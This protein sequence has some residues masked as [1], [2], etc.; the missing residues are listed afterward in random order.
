MSA[1]A[2]L[3]VA[4]EACAGRGGGATLDES[5]GGVST[6]VPVACWVDVATAIRDDPRSA[7]GFF[8]WLSAYDDSDHGL[9]VVA[10]V[11]SIG[12]RHAVVLR[13]HVAREG[14][15]LA[16][17]TGVWAGADWHE[18]ETY[19]MFAIDFTGHPRLVPLLLPN[20]FEG[21]PLRKDFVLATRVAMAWPGAKEPG[22]SDRDLVADQPGA[23]GP[24]GR[25]RRLRPPGVPEPG[26]WGAQP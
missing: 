26:T 9:A 1:A 15:A 17:L 6:D 16:T 20:G 2:L 14:G 24:R 22:E 8:D 5:Y 7:C 11:W 10:R 18:R 21:H 13:T 12:H 25:R 23:T 19:E 4:A 3:A